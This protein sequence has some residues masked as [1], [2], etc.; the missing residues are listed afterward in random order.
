MNVFYVS[1]P[2]NDQ[3]VLDEQES[4]HCVKVLRTRVGDKVN[5]ID[6]HGNFYE[7]VLHDDNPKRCVLAVISIR[8]DHHP[9]PYHLHVGIAPTKSIDR[10]E[11]FLEKATEIGI[12]S[13]T[14]LI[15][16][17]SERRMLR[18]DRLEKIIVSAMKQSKKAYKPTLLQAVEFQKWLLGEKAG[19]NLIAHCTEDSKQD[20]WKMDLQGSIKLAIGPE[21]DFTESELLLARDAGFEA[22]SLG[23]YRLRTETAGIMACSAVYFNKMQ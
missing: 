15:C 13:I 7:A 23:N 18:A 20:L 19:S 8:E 10:F 9:L 21:G 14:P 16:A 4:R 3:L 6:G 11:W 2:G 12:S 17:R 1:S 5:A 22:I